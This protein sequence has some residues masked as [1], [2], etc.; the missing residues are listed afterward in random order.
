M[1]VLLKNEKNL[2]PLDLTKLKTIAVIGP[3]AADVH[4][5]GYSRDPLHGVSVL[6]GIRAKVGDKAK[7]LYAE[8]CKITTAPQGY[9]GWSADNVEL[10]DPKTQTASIQAAVDVAKKSDVAILVVGENESTNREAWSE[11]HR[12][13][14]DSLDL[15][16]AQNDLVKAVVETGK[17]VV[18]FLINGRPLSINYI[19]EK[20]PAILRG[21]V[22]RAGRRNRRR[23]CDFWRCE[24]G[25]QAADY[26]S[27]H[28]GCAA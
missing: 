25:R 26:V 3:N 1:I 10:V 15:L 5:G 24:S 14:R 12:G 27:A 19:A 11:M 22:S 13:D 17:P 28:S 18:V 8:G 16:G 23:G 7:V 4:I 6:D 20:V 9:R 21:M 2:L